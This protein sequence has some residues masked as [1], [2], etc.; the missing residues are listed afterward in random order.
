MTDTP[1]DL[2]AIEE[3]IHDAPPCALTPVALA[4]LAGVRR[5]REGSEG[6]VTP[7]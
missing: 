3:R 5:L 1:L 4:L 7:G 2:D 6:H